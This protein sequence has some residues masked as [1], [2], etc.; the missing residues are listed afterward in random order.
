MSTSRHNPTGGASQ[1]FDNN[2]LEKVIA[3]YQAGDANALTE[4]V[5]LSRPRV[6][7]LIRFNGTADFRSEDEL[8]SDVNYK[9]VRSVGRFNS[10]KGSAFTFVSCLIQNALHTAVTSARKNASRYV[11]LDEATVSTLRTNGDG[12]TRDAVDDLADRIKRGVRT[13]L[14]DPAELQTTRWYV[15]SFLDGAF[16]LRRFKC[17]DAPMVVH[18]LSHERARELYDL[19]LL[20][21]R[22]VTYDSLPQQPT[23][24]AGRL[25]GTRSAWMLRYAHLL[26]AAEFDK[27]FRL[28]RDLSPFVVGAHRS[29]KQIETTG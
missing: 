8:I 14:S 28:S 19:C 27:F 23:I 16:E 20:E 15:T 25:V 26:D 1:H 11:E 6:E 21:C 22:R 5:A 18:G 3:R 4:I 7:T 24:A 2:R 12:Q 13:T 9:L 10:A 29:R 17:C